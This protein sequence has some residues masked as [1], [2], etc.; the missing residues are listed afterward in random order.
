MYN[1]KYH[2]HVP[3]LLWGSVPKVFNP[4]LTVS[5]NKYLSFIPNHVN[6]FAKLAEFC[7]YL[8]QRFPFKIKLSQ[9][10][11]YI[12]SFFVHYYVT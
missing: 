9:R 12:S 5:I 3:Y 4:V 2:K 10:T 1:I 6:Y 8:F 11:Y 7:F